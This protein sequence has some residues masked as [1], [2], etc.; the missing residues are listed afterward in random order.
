MNKF[1]KTG[2][3]IIGL[4]LSQ[5]Y[6]SA[7]DIIFP[8]KNPYSTTSNTSYI[9]GNVE[10]GA[11]LI[12]NNQKAKV[13]HNGAF[14]QSI[15]LSE[16]ENIFV[17]KEMHHKKIT[18]QTLK[19]TKPQTRT[20][21]TNKTQ[22][23]PPATINYKELQ[24]AIVTT[25]GAPVREKASTSGNRI[26]HLTKNTV[27]LLEKK[28]GDWY[29]IHTGSQD[30]QLWI[31]SKNVQI[32]YPVNNSVKVN[33]RNA[34]ISEDSLFSYL[35]INLDIPI[36]FKTQEN[37]K[38]IELTLFGIKDFD[39]L[40]SKIN[41]QKTFEK[42]NI[43]KDKNDNLVIKIDSSKAIWGYDIKYQGSTLIFKKRK[44]PLI[45]ENQPLKCITVAIDAGH[46][47]KEKGTI[48]PTRIPEKDVNLAISKYLEAELQKRG[49][50]VIMT[51]EDDSFVDLY[52]RPE[53]AKNKNALIS[54]SI[55]ANSM[56]DGNPL[57]RHGVS[58]FYYNEHAK[59]LADTIK[60]RMATD[61]KLKDD[62]TRY[63]SFVL[64]RPAMPV[65]ILIE[66]AYMPNPDEYLKLT[67]K[68]FQYKT[69]KSIAD[70]L[71]EYLLNMK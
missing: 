24:Y 34:E 33:I 20:A 70:G 11:S 7:L 62:G 39:I 19:I 65:S 49:A 56:V 1:L 17:L 28:Y 13:W 67:N 29:K 44:P 71:E 32:K 54:I 3:F 47:G 16:G 64:T 69:A 4:T 9:M 58:V 30:E 15:N 22:Y 46:G 35:K 12:I 61:L 48:G 53:I 6:A 21:N 55:H 23:T 37:G 10:K 25:D 52:S 26:V 2:I 14:C 50:I 45:N 51:R 43:V 31:Y 27:V 8:Q 38:N 59:I 42:I 40:C 68:H 66:T 36:L 41:K 57:E 63:S 5:E 60:T 18:Q